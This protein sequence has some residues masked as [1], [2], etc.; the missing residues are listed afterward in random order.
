MDD[1]CEFHYDRGKPGNLGKI[2]ETDC[3]FAFNCY[4]CEKLVCVGCSEDNPVLVAN[5][6]I[7]CGPPAGHASM[8]SSW[9]LRTRPTPTIKPPG[10]L[11]RSHY[12][13]DLLTRP[14]IGTGEFF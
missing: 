14:D 5:E 6:D 4:R 2:Y 9:T 1:T 12:T 8:T 10:I 11:P 7:Q 3:S 13:G